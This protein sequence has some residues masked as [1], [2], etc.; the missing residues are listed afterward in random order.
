MTRIKKTNHIEK[1]KNIEPINNFSS[2]KKPLN[3]KGEPSY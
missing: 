2:L 1:N 3:D